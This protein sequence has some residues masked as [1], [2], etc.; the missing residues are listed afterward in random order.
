MLAVGPLKPRYEPG[1][2]AT[3]KNEVLSCVNH[4]EARKESPGINI[5]YNA[6][7]ATIQKEYTSVVLDNT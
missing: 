6:V 4:T 5:L 2:E 3:G 1:H 7:Q